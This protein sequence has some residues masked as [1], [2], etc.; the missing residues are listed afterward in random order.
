MQ[1]RFRLPLDE[2]LRPTPGS[3]QP[4]FSLVLAG[5]NSRLD[6]SMLQPNLHDRVEISYKIAPSGN[7]YSISGSGQWSDSS[8]YDGDAFFIRPSGFNPDD[9]LSTTWQPEYGPRQHPVDLIDNLSDWNGWPYRNRPRIF[10]TDQAALF[11]GTVAR[12]TYRAPVAPPPPPPVPTPPL[13]RFALPDGPHNMESDPV[14]SPMSDEQSRIWR[15]MLQN[16]QDAYEPVPMLHFRLIVN[17][18]ATRMV[19]GERVLFIKFFTPADPGY[20]GAG[21]FAIARNYIFGNRDTNYPAYTDST[22][23]NSMGPWYK[24][25]LAYTDIPNLA[26]DFARVLR[27]P[28]LTSPPLPVD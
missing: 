1:N 21:S 6:I 24:S 26:A 2:N 23:L 17:G 25:S 9:W 5:I 3:R 16:I 22:I 19:V 15:L 27:I 4:R 18:T 7:G 20:V 11:F 10:S 12:M 8:R 14:I 28:P 13:A